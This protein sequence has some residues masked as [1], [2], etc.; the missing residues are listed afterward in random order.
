[1][2]HLRRRLTLTVVEWEELGVREILEH[3]YV[4]IEDQFYTPEAGDETQNTTCVWRGGRSRL[5]KRDGDRG[6]GMQG[7]HG[8]SSRSSTKKPSKR[9]KHNVENGALAC[10]GKDSGILREDECN[11]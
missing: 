2:N 8:Q 7:N 4:Q 10:S 11:G 3:D 5:W 9:A 6:S 1:M